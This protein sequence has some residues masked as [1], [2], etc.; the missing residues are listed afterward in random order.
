MENQYNVPASM[1]YVRGAENRIAM[2]VADRYDFA[3]VS[4]YAA[5]NF[6]KEKIS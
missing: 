5:V 4:K 1:A 6:K 2:L 3:V